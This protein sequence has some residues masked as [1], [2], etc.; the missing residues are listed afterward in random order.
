M[1]RSKKIR[2]EIA[3]TRQHLINET[4]EAIDQTRIEYEI[5][6]GHRLRLMASIEKQNALVKQFAEDS[7]QYNI[8]KREAE[9]DQKLYDNLLERLKQAGVSV[10]LKASNIRVLESA[11][12]ATKPYSPDV[13]LNLTLGLATGLMLGLCVAA[14]MEFLDRNV[15][16]PGDVEELLG[17]PVLATI[18]Q[19][20]ESWAK[21]REQL[22][23]PRRAGG[24]DILPLRSTIPPS[25][26]DIL[27]LRSTMPPLCQESYRSLRTKLLL[28]SPGGPPKTVL[29]TS[30][31]P[32]EGKTT[33]CFNLA[34]SLA[35]TGARTLLLELD[36]RLPTLAQRFDL[37]N[38][39]GLSHYL[40]GR[41]V[42]LWSLV[43]E[44]GVRNLSAILSGP[45]PPNPADLIASPRMKEALTE[46][47]RSFDIVIIDS[48]PVLPVTDAIIAAPITDGTLLVVRGGKT[49]RK[50]VQ[51]AHEE[52][53]SV[54]TKILGVVVNDVNPDRAGM[55][56]YSRYYNQQPDQG[57]AG[58]DVI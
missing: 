53:L 38:G 35:M 45:K 15:D 39:K 24:T 12:V 37:K 52:L 19:L 28:S 9:T 43:R 13:P 41:S 25:C 54:G 2:N 31:L 3:D 32:G 11:Q 16:T 29:V 18:P 1:A 58:Q 55:K 23:T 8:L 30:A 17:F 57:H 6:Q 51:Q 49:Q 50:A 21:L 48:P 7:I 4:R 27:P 36:M 44:T 40:A 56:Y 42:S 46:L 14:S 5:A 10:G 47:S 33:T 20:G 34:V 26:T 22:E